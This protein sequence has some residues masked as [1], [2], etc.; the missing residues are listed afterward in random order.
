LLTGVFGLKNAVQLA[1]IWDTAEPLDAPVAVAEG[2]AGA[3]VAG[4][5]PDPAGGAELEGEPLLH[6]AAPVPS[7]HKS[8][9][10]G[11]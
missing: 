8:A 5:V 11:T 10:S 1:V 9:S 3:E 2:L 7:A 6:A 4:E